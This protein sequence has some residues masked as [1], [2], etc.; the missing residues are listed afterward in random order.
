MNISGDF[1]LFLKKRSIVSFFFLV[2]CGG[3]VASDA[4]VPAAGAGSG[5]ARRYVEVVDEEGLSKLNQD[6]M[7]ELAG[8]RS[9]DLFCETLLHSAAAYGD[10][11]AIRA[12]VYWGADV[13]AQDHSGDIPLHKAVRNFKKGAIASL[14]L[15]GANID[16]KNK[17]GKTARE[18]FG[19]M[20][21][22]LFDRP[23]QDS[24]ELGSNQELLFDLGMRTR[25]NRMLLD[26]AKGNRRFSGIGLALV[27]GAD[28]AV[29]DEKGNTAL[30]V[31]VCPVYTCHRMSEPLRRLFPCLDMLALLVRH[32]VPVCAVNNEKKTAEEVARNNDFIAVANFLASEM[33]KAEMSRSDKK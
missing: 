8:R 1:M 30:H 24:L 28:V 5:A 21:A 20:G 15:F 3:L 25:A 31:A 2:F 10:I 6:L 18:C 12:L 26:A 27:A 17:E 11:D 7:R 19:E 29:V 32:G 9:E 14:Q 16:I 13:N 4:G 33:K 23:Y 22:A